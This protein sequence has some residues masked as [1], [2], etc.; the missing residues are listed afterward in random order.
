MLLLLL[1]APLSVFSQ[2]VSLTTEELKILN[3]TITQQ[4]QMI[5]TLKSNLEESQTS[6]KK[7][8][9][10]SKKNSLKIV[11]PTALTSFAA[12]IVTGLVI[13]SKVN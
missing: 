1:V 4:Q 9:N 10:S 12:G 7:L 6:M 3:E 11:I 8:Q 13:Y 2:E 5:V